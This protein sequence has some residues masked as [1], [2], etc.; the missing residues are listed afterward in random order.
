MRVRVATVAAMVAATLAAL[1]ATPAAAADVVGRE[2]LVNLSGSVLRIEVRRSQGG[3]G[4]GSGVVLP[5]QRI[6]TNCHVTRDAVAVHVLRGG[7]RWLADAQA[8]LPELDVCVLHVP[9]LVG[10]PVPLAAGVEVGQPVA[11]LGYMG[12]MA[13]PSVSD[14]VVMDLH[15][16]QGADV[17]QSSTGFI[18]GA[19]GGGLF[20]A[21]GALAGILTFSLR[22]GDA[23][24]FA[25][26][27][28]WLEPL[29]KDESR[30][31]PVAPLPRVLTYWELVADAQPRFLR[32]VSL[33]HGGFWDRLLGLATGWAREDE[34]DP[35]AHYWHGMALHKLARLDDAVRPLERAVEL[36]ARWDAPL[37]SLGLVELQR[38][39][40]QAARHILQRL[41][42]LRD[43]AG[44]RL[45]YA[46]SKACARESAS[47][48]PS[49]SA[50]SS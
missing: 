2:R 19:S 7:A 20:D 3:Y 39:R 15:R 9:D 26:P 33:A 6:V 16:H 27:V 21:R 41:Q 4:Y 28:A 8:A 34:R 38:G 22:G 50:C 49:S 47:K 5:G 29:L 37:E 42:A 31:A 25:A 14:G 1:A 23:H 35:H 32:A 10:T 43:G 24:Y 13:T 30:F 12:G 17:I 36:A 45:R 46:L 48:S 18:S 44:E 40:P 11:A